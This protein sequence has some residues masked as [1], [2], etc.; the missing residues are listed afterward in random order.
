[1]D[2]DWLALLVIFLIV[3]VFFGGK[4]LPGLG[5]SMGQSIRGFKSGLQGAGQEKSVD[6][7]SDMR[8]T[9][10]DASDVTTESVAN[11]WRRHN[12]KAWRR[13][14]VSQV[15]RNPQH[16]QALWP[17]TL[18]GAWWLSRSLWPTWQISAAPV[19][20][21]AAAVSGMSRQRRKLTVDASPR[22]M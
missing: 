8:V 7:E 15:A 9:S 13:G 4:R 2:M 10:S 17:G 16:A 14:D 1:M 18:C 22:S 3:L 19:N 5:K 11:R 12:G 21:V 6:R 20:G